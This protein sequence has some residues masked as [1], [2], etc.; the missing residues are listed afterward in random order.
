VPG[1]PHFLDQLPLWAS[2]SLVPLVTDWNLLTEEKPVTVFSAKL[3]G[4]GELTM[5]PLD[6]P[7]HAPIVHEWVVKPR[8]RFWGMTDHS[9]DQVREIYAYVEGLDTHHAY[10]LLLDD[11]PIGVFQT[12]DPGHDPVGECYDVQ[13]GDVGMHLLIDAAGR[14]LPHLTSAVFPALMGHLF[15]GPACRRIVA[16]P[17]I[18][19]ERM[20]NRLRR[21]GYTL[22]DEIDLG[23]KRA[24]LAFLT[25]PDAP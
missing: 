15:A 4:L 12:Y 7:A 2:G 8:N 23:P 19:N 10:L 18:R 22:G 25:R 16:E 9:V 11:G 21:E 1:T 6:P 5:V 20:I 14:D 13:P 3:P 17:D 24:R